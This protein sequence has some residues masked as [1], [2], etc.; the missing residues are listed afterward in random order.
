MLHLPADEPKIAQIAQNK[1]VANNI[2]IIAM[3]T[4]LTSRKILLLTLLLRR[5]APEVTV[6]FLHI[7]YKRYRQPQ[8]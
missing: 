2:A 5:S 3:V 4:T 6:T 8:T 1:H 7:T